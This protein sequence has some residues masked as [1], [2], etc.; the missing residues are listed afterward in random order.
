MSPKNL[1]PG[2][3]AKMGLYEADFSAENGGMHHFALQN[4]LIAVFTSVAIN[5]DAHKLLHMTV[6]LCLENGLRVF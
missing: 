1:F 5:P 2:N 3:F 6:R 4:F